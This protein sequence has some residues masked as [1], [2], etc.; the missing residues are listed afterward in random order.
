MDATIHE[1]DVLTND[2]LCVRLS[3][4]EHVL[5]LALN[6]GDAPATLA[7]P[8]PETRLIFGHDATTP[9]TDDQIEVPAHS[10]AVLA[11]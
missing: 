6:L 11:G 8:S 7:K 1:P 4:G 10:I 3:A 9:D 2:L 5:A